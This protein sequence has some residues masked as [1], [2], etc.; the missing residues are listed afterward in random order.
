[1][2]VAQCFVL[3]LLFSFVPGLRLA[4]GLTP[5]MWWQYLM[6]LGWGSINF[7]GNE[8]L[9]KPIARRKIA[10]QIAARREEMKTIN[11]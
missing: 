2:T 8:W 6:A 11:V 10:A 9:A 3:T 1:M 7:L 5:I 4:L